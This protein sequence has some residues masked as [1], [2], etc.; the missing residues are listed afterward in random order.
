MADM[1]CGVF[2]KKIIYN[3]ETGKFI[4]F[5]SGMIYRAEHMRPGPY[6]GPE[7]YGAMYTDEN[8]F[9]GEMVLQPDQIKLIEYAGKV[10]LT[11]TW[12]GGN[13]SDGYKDHLFKSVYGHYDRKDPER[14]SAEINAMAL[15]FQLEETLNQPEPE[16]IIA[17]WD[18]MGFELISNTEEGSK[19]LRTLYQEM[20]NRNVAISRGNKF[21]FD[22]RPGL[23][24]LVVSELSDEDYRA[25][26]EREDGKPHRKCENKEQ[27]MPYENCIYEGPI[28]FTVDDT[29]LRGIAGQQRSGAIA[30][31]LQQIRDA[32]KGIFKPIL[33]DKTRE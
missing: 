16:D 25:K 24:F 9:G 19:I 27:A 10:L 7:L 32:V 33:K 26:R 20:Q 17:L 12:V 15:K 18:N 8:P 2:G 30:L 22:G 13:M 14:V 1:R 29:S 5:N 21:M 3:E 11:N 6:E 31:C 23:S 28:Y 4:G